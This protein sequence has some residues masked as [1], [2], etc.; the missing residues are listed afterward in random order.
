MLP[1]ASPFH[2]DEY[3]TG[4]CHFR[5]HESLAML[6]IQLEH[7]QACS[8]LDAYQNASQNMLQ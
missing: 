2:A 4:I 3:C 7:T 8:H 5:Y 6:A 1:L